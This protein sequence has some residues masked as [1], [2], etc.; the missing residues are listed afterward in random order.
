MEEQVNPTQ[1]LSG[2][3]T[4]YF[5]IS[6][7]RFGNLSSRAKNYSSITEE[8]RSNF[9]STTASSSLTSTGVN[10]PHANGTPGSCNAPLVF[11]IHGNRFGV[12]K[13][14]D[15]LDLPRDAV[16]GS[17]LLSLN[18]VKVSLLIEVQGG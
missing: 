18:D 14:C 4:L 2:W 13:C 10:P 1:S 3:D 12:T 16:H 11:C 7:S 9:A 17:H 8:S 15:H 6:L 5:P